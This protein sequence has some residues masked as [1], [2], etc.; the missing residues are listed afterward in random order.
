[1]NKFNANMDNRRRSAKERA[2]AWELRQL[3][4]AGKIS[5]LSEQVS[6]NL[7]PKQEGEKPVVYWA[8]FT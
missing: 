8:D 6:F 3:E 7:L 2:R 1:M 4:K 5:G